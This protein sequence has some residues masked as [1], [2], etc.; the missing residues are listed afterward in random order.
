MDFLGVV[1]NSSN[2]PY[3][4]NTVNYYIGNEAIIYNGRGVINE[5]NDFI[6]LQYMMVILIYIKQSKIQH[7]LNLTGLTH[8][9]MLQQLLIHLQTT[10]LLYISWAT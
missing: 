5:T 1:G 3:Q 2:L 10:L 7:Y 8:T 9:K 6:T 4:T